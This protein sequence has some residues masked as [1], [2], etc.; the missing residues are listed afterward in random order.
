MVL[1]MGQ[2][3]V[4][5]TSILQQWADGRIDELWDPT[6]EDD[7]K[8]MVDV[9]GT[10]VKMHGLEYIHFP[11]SP[12]MRDCAI[13]VANSCI[14]L[15]SVT[16]RESFEHVA[17]LRN[18]VLQMKAGMTPCSFL[19]CGNK[20]DLTTERVVTCD[21]PCTIPTHLYQRVLEAPHRWICSSVTFP[22]GSSDNEVVTAALDPR[23]SVCILFID[24]LRSF[25]EAK[26]V[27][28]RCVSV[29]HTQTS[30]YGDTLPIS[31]AEFFMLHFPLSDAEDRGYLLVNKETG[32]E[33]AFIFDNHHLLFIR[34]SH[35]EMWLICM[36]NPH[37]I[38][39]PISRE[40]GV[41][42]TQN[43]STISRNY[44]DLETGQVLKVNHSNNTSI[45]FAALG[46]NHH[47]GPKFKIKQ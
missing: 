2:Q 22:Q 20:V 31:S 40:Y 38:I 35:L 29:L 3:G 7:R 47:L 19:L 10:A 33:I 28:L 36:Q 11:S 37:S 13:H 41:S 1:I 14:I 26:L 34:P 9:D 4:G 27:V 42:D 5:K 18:R 16:S 30:G 6:I 8:K 21:N 46:L 24:L 12:P 39:Q 32:Q 15:Y 44:H 23:G 45:K 43:G 25:M 17:D